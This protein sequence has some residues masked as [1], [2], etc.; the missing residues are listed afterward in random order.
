MSTTMATTVQQF[1][2]TIDENDHST[3]QVVP[4]EVRGITKYTDDFELGM[5]MCYFLARRRHTFNGYGFCKQ[6]N[7]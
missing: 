6:Y 2:Q 7:R 5:N 3:Q 4:T 1:E